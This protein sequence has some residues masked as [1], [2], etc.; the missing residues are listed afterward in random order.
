MKKKFVSILSLVL[1]LSSCS[2]DFEFGFLSSF[3]SNNP[4]VS[5]STDINGPANPPSTKVTTSKGEITSNVP[6]SVDNY[7][8][9][10][11]TKYTLKDINKGINW[12]TLN[13]TGNQKVLVV[14]VHFKSAASWTS[15]KLENLNNVFFGNANDTNW[16]SVKTYFNKSSYGNLSISGEVYSEV[17]EVNMTSTTFD[18]KYYD[19]Y[20]NNVGTV[21][22]D[23]GEYMG[24]LLHNS[25]TDSNLLKEYDQDKDG[26]IDAVI[27]CYSNA[28]SYDDTSVFWAWV[29]GAYLDANVNKPTT[30]IHVWVSYEFINDTYQSYG[31][32]TGLDGHTFIHEMGH[33]LGLDDYYC[34]DTSNKWDPAGALD[35]QSYN[36]GDHNI[37]SKFSLGWVD[38]YVVTG[39]ADIK[40]RS[41]ALYGDAILIKNDWNG[42]IFD[43]Y[44]LIEYYT[45]EGLNE[46]DSLYGFGGR[47]K[48]FTYSG[49]RIYHVDARLVKIGRNDSFYGDNSGYIE[50]SKIDSALNATDGSIAYIGASNSVSLSH[51]TSSQNPSEIRLL[52]LIDKGGRNTIY[53]GTKANKSNST[54]INSSDALWTTGDVFEA[55]GSYFYSGKNTFNDGT[56]VG[57]KVTVGEV[58]NGEITVSVRVK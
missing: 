50:N 43:E 56:T 6:G 33:I 37:Y 11:D 15:A 34:Y 58:E 32:P 46:Q 22:Y 29:S 54:L 42:T 20:Y 9:A 16:E 5:N 17:L 1:L 26:Y 4:T 13:S 21:S 7:Y 47:D 49:L 28:Y 19:Y 53:E 31:A 18:S 44:I 45:P 41:S 27:Y 57:Y 14:P 10:T 35:M 23:P 52:H 24:T 12:N 39:D 48:M 55:M 36:I 2:I 30:N 8:K 40:L 51:L 3:I 38:P 25:I